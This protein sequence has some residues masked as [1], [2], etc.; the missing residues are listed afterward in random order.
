MGGCLALA[1]GFPTLKSGFVAL[2]YSLLVLLPGFLAL[3]D[4]P[5]LLHVNA[6][7]EPVR[8]PHAE[9]ILKVAVGH[10]DIA[11][12]SRPRASGT[13]SGGGEADLLAQV[14]EQRSGEADEGP[15]HVMTAVAYHGIR[16]SDERSE[17]GGCSGEEEAN[18]DIDSGPV[19]SQVL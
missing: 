3:P 13:I 19:G 8:E 16:G 1:T 5:A 10:I 7:T 14:D 12:V 9:P 4:R 15:S 2:I 18:G 6:S 17:E 11:F